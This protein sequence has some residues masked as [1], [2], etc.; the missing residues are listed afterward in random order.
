MQGGGEHLDCSF[1]CS[2]EMVLDFEWKRIMWHL[3]SFFIIIHSNYCVL[4]YIC[5]EANN[6]Y[7]NSLVVYLC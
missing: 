1:G 6:K 2:L 3:F 5:S 4:L 7:T